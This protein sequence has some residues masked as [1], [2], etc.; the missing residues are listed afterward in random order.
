MIKPFAMAHAFSDHT[1]P[2]HLAPCRIWESHPHHGIN[3]RPPTLSRHLGSHVITVGFSP[4][5]AVLLGTYLG[6]RVLHLLWGLRASQ[7]Q[8]WSHMMVQ[9]RAFMLRVMEFSKIRWYSAT[10]GPSS[11]CPPIRC[12]TTL[13]PSA[14]PCQAPEPC[15]PCHSRLVTG[16][17]RTR[18]S[19][20]P[21]MPH[22]G[23]FGIAVELSRCR[24]GEDATRCPG[25]CQPLI[26]RGSGWPAVPSHAAQTAL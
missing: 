16:R 22:V 24:A 10:P 7:G 8:T 6:S 20:T 5:L 23:G 21:E 2:F 1:K 13:S 19:R 26:S 25:T 11:R 4:R 17:S 3:Y 18:E 9:S 14:T 15:G 12:A